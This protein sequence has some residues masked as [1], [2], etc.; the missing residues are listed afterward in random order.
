MEIKEDRLNLDFYEQIV[1]YKS[2]TNEQYLGS[3]IDHIKPEYFNDKNIRRIYALI[4]NFYNKN[5]ALPSVTEVKSY[6]INDELK[7]SFKTVVKNF[8]TIDRDFNNKELLSSTERFIKERAIYNTMLSVAEDV[9]SGKVNTSF[10]LDAFEKS[11]NI[12]LKSE[13]G[14]DLLKDIDTVIDDLKREEP[15]STP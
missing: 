14:L 2:L 10:I 4:K 1:I 9:S 3:V 6:L 15:F 5:H 7:E 12:D 13:I 11:C 8:T